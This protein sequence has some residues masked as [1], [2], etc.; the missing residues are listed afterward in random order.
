M[1]LCQGAFWKSGIYGPAHCCPSLK[2]PLGDVFGRV[3]RSLQIAFDLIVFSESSLLAFGTV[4][5]LKTSCHGKM[6]LGFNMAKGHIAPISILSTPRL[7]L[8]AAVLATRMTQSIIRKMRIPG[9][10]KSSIE[11][12][13]Y[14]ENV[15]HQINSSYHKHPTF[16]PNRIGEILRHSSSFSV[17][18]VA[19]VAASLS[20]AGDP[21]PLIALSVRALHVS[22]LAFKTSSSAVSKLI[23]DSQNDLARLKRD[24]AL[25]LHEE[26]DRDLPITDEE[27]K[28]A[29]RTCIIVTTEEVFQKEIIALRSGKLIP[30]V[31]VLR[32]VSPKINPTDGLMKMD[33]RIKHALSEHVRQPVILP[34]DHRH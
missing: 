2:F 19:V 1:S 29:M 7:E 5:Y 27:L 34:S 30:R 9:I 31:S 6:H 11:Y 14:S 4:T 10:P 24:V 22:F 16:V 18:P 25:S 20:Q 13:T 21:D 15:L 28:Q 17:Y 26:T 12:R 33:G 8:Q 32:N 23:A 3:T